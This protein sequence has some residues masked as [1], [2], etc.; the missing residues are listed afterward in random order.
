LL[1]FAAIFYP[2]NEPDVYALCWVCINDNGVFLVLRMGAP[3]FWKTYLGRVD[4][5]RLGQCVCYLVPYGSDGCGSR[6]A[7]LLDMGKLD[8]CDW[9]DN[10]GFSVSEKKGRNRPGGPS[11][12]MVAHLTRG[13]IHK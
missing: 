10:D 11:C 5:T 3:S 13:L 7:P 1:A 9:F 8:L 2:G 4:Y 6:T 12:S